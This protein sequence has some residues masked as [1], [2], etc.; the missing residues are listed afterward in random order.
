[1][2]L[3]KLYLL[4]HNLIDTLNVKLEKD[5]ST[6]KYKISN[7]GK[8]NA[9]LE[10]LST[11]SYFKDE[12][13]NLRQHPHILEIFT[14][15]AIVDSGAAFAYQSEIKMIREKLKL[16]SMLYKD[17]SP[18]L[19]ENTLCISA[20]KNMSL[21]EFQSFV[22]NTTKALNMLNNMDG[23]EGHITF[24]NVE[25]GSD[26]FYYIVEGVSL[27][28]GIRLIINIAKNIVVESITTYRTIKAVNLV[29]EST[30]TLQNLQK[31]LA[32]KYVN[33]DETFNNLSPENV[34]R[35]TNAIVL[36]ATEISKGAKTEM[37]LLN[38]AKS[39]SDILTEKQ[40]ANCVNDLKLLESNNT[41]EDLGD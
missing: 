27:L 29:H 11:F 41:T 2:R 23:M 6:S 3:S 33:E 16:I 22:N 14:D 21:P 28:A 17:F 4:T 36:L 12:F 40:I 39:E 8:I 24:K 18:Q 1:M 37:L 35:I 15:Y 10:I 25:Y 13:A 38:Q 9:S 20:P 31:G 34:E 26:W 7:I 32:K 30:I 19:D 5:P